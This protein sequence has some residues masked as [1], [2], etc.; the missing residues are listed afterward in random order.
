MPERRKRR[1][2]KEKKRSDKF[3]LYEEGVRKDEK[4]LR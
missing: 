3:E 1:K 2:K 4:K